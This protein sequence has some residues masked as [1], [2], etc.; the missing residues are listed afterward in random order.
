MNQLAA[1]TR[2]ALPRQVPTPRTESVWPDEHVVLLAHLLGDGSSLRAAVPGYAG[3]DQQNLRAVEHAAGGFG[4]TARRDFSASARGS[5]LRL[6]APAGSGRGRRHPVVV[7]LDGL[8][9][10]GV[11]RRDTFVPADVACLSKRQVRLFLHHLWSTRGSVSTDGRICF[12]S[13]SRRLCDDIGR[14]LLRFGISTRLAQVGP[15]VW[16]RWTLEVCGPDDQ[17]RFLGEIGVHGAAG[18]HADKLLVSIEGQTG[19]DVEPDAG[20]DSRLVDMSPA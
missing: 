2:L 3:F 19:G 1:G 8:G 11:R 9:L 6:P 14:L 13:P 7:W 12:S 18:R 20:H 16:R 15:P 10:R 4:I 17:R 5:S